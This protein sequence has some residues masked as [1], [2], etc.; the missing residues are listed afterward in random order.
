M[1]RKQPIGFVEV[2]ANREVINPFN[3]VDL[4][5]CAANRF[6]TAHGRGHIRGRRNQRVGIEGL[7]IGKPHTL[8]Q[9]KDP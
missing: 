2:D 4:I 9:N 3:S 8:A 6:R 1:K 7:A 5:E